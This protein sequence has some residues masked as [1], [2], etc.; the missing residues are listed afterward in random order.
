MTKHL[1][2]MTEVNES[3]IIICKEK[4]ISPQE[5]DIYHYFYN[6][7]TRY[8]FDICE[9]NTLHFYKRAVAGRKERGSLFQRK[10]FPM[11]FP[12]ENDENPGGQHN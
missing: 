11:V 6:H 1:I 5:K 10:I 4:C 2:L 12:K 7:F 8:Y 9:Q 3:F